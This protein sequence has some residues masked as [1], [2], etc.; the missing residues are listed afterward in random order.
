VTFG[1]EKCSMGRN[2]QARYPNPAQTRSEGSRRGSVRTETVVI[3][4]AAAFFL[5]LV[6]GAIWAI[7]RTPPLPHTNAMPVSPK[8]ADQPTDVSGHLGDIGV[9]SELAQKGLKDPDGW[10]ELGDLFSRNQ[11]HD[12]AAEAYTKALALQPDNADTLVK[13][14]NAYFDRGAYEEAIKAYSTALTIEPQNA[15]VLTDLGVAYRRT[16]NPGRA[17][18]AFRKAASI[19]PMHSSSR[20]NQ[21]VVLFHDLNDTE[22]A[23]RA[24]QAFLQVEPKGERAEKVRHMVEVLKAISPGPQPGAPEE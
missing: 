15:D 23:V 18:N 20:Y 16:K 10:T 11:Q 14:G 24:W 3:L 22:G 5:G 9:Q 12:K 21:G 13:L 1:N 19:D 17:L 6:V 2:S 4:V 8:T 7:L